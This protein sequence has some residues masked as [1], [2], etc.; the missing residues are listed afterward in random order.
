[1]IRIL[2]LAACLLSTRVSVAD[3]YKDGF[4]AYSRGDYPRALKVLRPLAESGNIYAQHSLGLMFEKGQGVNQDYEKALHW[5]YLAAEQG[6]MAAQNN[7]GSMLSLT[8]VMEPPMFGVMEPQT[9]S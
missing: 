8:A 6:L 1:M 5:Y 4:D 2:I 7:I 3:S 9:G